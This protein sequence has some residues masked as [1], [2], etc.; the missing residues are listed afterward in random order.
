MSDLFDNVKLYLTQKTKNKCLL[1]PDI[2]RILGKEEV[3]RRIDEPVY[4]SRTTSVW[5]Y[6]SQATGQIIV[7]KIIMAHDFNIADTV[8]RHADYRSKLLRMVSREIRLIPTNDDTVIVPHAGLYRSDDDCGRLSSERRCTFYEMC[9]LNT[10]TQREHHVIWGAQLMQNAVCSLNIVVKNLHTTGTDSNFAYF[11]LA[12]TVI[13]KLAYLKKTRQMCHVDF[14][15]E[16]CGMFLTKDGVDIKL[17]DT[18]GIVHRRVQGKIGTTYPAAFWHRNTVRNPDTVSD[19]DAMLWCIGVSLLQLSNPTKYGAI[20]SAFSHRNNVFKN[21]RLTENLLRKLIDPIQSAIHEQVFFSLA[22]RCMRIS[23]SKSI[24]S[25]CALERKF[26]QFELVLNIQN[27]SGREF[28]RM[29][30]V[31]H[32]KQT[33]IRPAATSAIA[34]QS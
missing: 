23:K 21:V 15:W 10:H 16:N 31:A 22:T 4:T 9:A 7:L 26:K 12:K 29:Y 25:V 32:V 3:Y 19:E 8:E 34:L 2:V 24:Q 33:A 11:H 5:R 1:V 6:G 17:L 13:S 30:A 27:N 28:L 14:K 20:A 18:A